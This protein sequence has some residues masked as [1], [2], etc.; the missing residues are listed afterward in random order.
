MRKKNLIETLR[1]QLNLAKQERQVA[2][3]QPSALAAR[4]ALKD[5]QSARL[6]STHADLLAAA[7]THAAAVFFLSELYGSKDMTQRDIDIERIIPTL[8]RVLPYRALEALTKAIILDA[9]SESL[10]SAMAA[11]LGENFSPQAYIA[12]FRE[13]TR[14]EERDRQVDLVQ[15]L[16]ESLSELVRIPLLAATLSMMRGPAKMA[17]LFGLQQFLET[18]FTTFKAMKRPHAFVRA[19]TTR[20]KNIIDNIYECRDDPFILNFDHE[21]TLAI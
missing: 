9:L 10:D 3:S 1:Q 20:E 21:S 11:R 16:G 4:I 17:G 7:D 14:K 18:G 19:I 2:K 13:A 12:A 5:F 6:A 8:E 15:S